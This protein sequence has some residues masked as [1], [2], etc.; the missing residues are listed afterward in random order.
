MD[1][2]NKAALAKR[3]VIRGVPVAR[4]DDRA[5]GLDKAPNQAVDRRDNAIAR[6]NGERTSRTEIVLYVDDDQRLVVPPGHLRYSTA[7]ANAPPIHE[8]VR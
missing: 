7:V 6:V 1:L 8:V 5:A 4:G 2:G 3:A